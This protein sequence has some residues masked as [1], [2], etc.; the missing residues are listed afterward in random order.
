MLTCVYVRA[1]CK[2]CGH[3]MNGDLEARMHAGSSGHKD[4]VQA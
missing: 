1:R 4:F 3:I 2:A